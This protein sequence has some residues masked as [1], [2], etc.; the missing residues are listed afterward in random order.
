MPS[1]REEYR[2][3]R[4]AVLLGDRLFL[5]YETEVRIF[6]LRAVSRAALD[7]GTGPGASR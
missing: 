1:K 5:L 2:G 3:L 7:L 6:G 4:D